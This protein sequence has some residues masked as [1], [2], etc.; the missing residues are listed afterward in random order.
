MNFRS[1]LFVCLFVSGLF[2]CFSW[3]ANSRALPE[4]Q[5]EVLSNGLK[6]VWFL[7]SRIPM[8]DLTLVVNQAGSVSDPEGKSGTAELVSDLLDRGAAGKTSHE[9]ARTIESLGASRILGVDEESMSVGIHGLAHDADQLLELL[10]EM[11]LQPDFSTSEFEL[12]KTEMLE[13]WSHLG[14]RSST[15]A[16]LLLLEKLQIN[17]SMLAVVLVSSRVSFDLT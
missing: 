17:L 6:I 16:S 12:K 11:A 1:F 8:V 10:A 15:L 3:S 2:P 13:S 7:D 5:V 4:P 9:F 14:D